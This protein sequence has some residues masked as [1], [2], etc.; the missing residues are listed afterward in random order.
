MIKAT[1]QHTK[2]LN[3]QLV[4]K[5][6]YDRAKISRADIARETQLTRTTVS[7]VVSQLMGQGL[8][9]EVGYGESAG[10]KSP[11]LLSVVNNRYHL[12]GIDLAS[13]EFRGA[14]VNLRGEIIRAV[15]FPIS[16]RSGEAALTLV[17]KL[18][19]T[20]LAS[21]DRPVLGLGLGTPGLIDTEQGI[22]RQAVNLDWQDLPLSQLLNARYH[23]PVYLVNDSQAA[24]LAEF[25]F[26]G[27]QNNRD[28]V[29]IKVDQGI[30]AGLV[31]DGQ[32]FVGDGSSAG[33]IGHM[34]VVEN[35]LPCRCGHT[36]CL[37]T[38]ASA[39][40]IIRRAQALARASTQS[41]LSLLAPEAITLE[42]LGA[43]LEAND[44]VAR[45]V[46]AEAGLYLGRAVAALVSTLNPR[47]VLLIGSITTLGVP[48]LKIIQQ[49][50]RRQALAILAQA[51]KIQFGHFGLDVVIL[52]A[53]AQL[54]THELG[55]SFAR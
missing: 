53:S 51:T 29:V 21:S 24:A 42:A 17:Y 35:D 49:E 20:L 41:R 52:G 26:G 31:L 30:G 9:E 15:A 6:I 14:V 10:G 43:A 4:L 54:L 11:I 38:V 1:R 8:V 27:W 28:L 37:E 25:I 39:G 34:M 32:L 2:T 22:V 45:Q 47:Q 12:I 46:T 50:T 36:G 5:L 55:L 40:A 16:G 48:L 3:S 18:I 13:H 44:P 23:L 33:E 7:Q 19:D